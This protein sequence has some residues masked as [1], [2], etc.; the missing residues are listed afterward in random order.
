MTGFS[1]KAS[2]F[3]FTFEDTE[4]D[5]G[6]EETSDS[7]MVKLFFWSTPKTVCPEGFIGIHVAP[8]ETQKWSIHYRFFTHIPSGDETGCAKSLRRR[9][10]LLTVPQRASVSEGFSPRGTL[11]RVCT[12]AERL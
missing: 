11:F 4:H 12:C 10:R 8:G 2:D 3:D 7:P 6:V 5:L 1:D 9:A